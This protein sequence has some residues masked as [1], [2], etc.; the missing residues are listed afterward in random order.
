MASSL[1]HAKRAIQ[2]GVVRA[3][4]H[5]W[6][7]QK[8]RL[9]RWR[10]MEKSVLSIVDGGTHH[11]GQTHAI[12]IIWQPIKTSWSV[13][14]MLGALD[15]AGVNVTLVV[16]HPLPDD[17]I[18]ALGRRVAR[19]MLRDNSGRD[20]GGYRDATL[21]LEREAQPERVLYLNDS[22]Y[23]FE[24]GLDP[25]VKRLVDS[26][27]DV[28]TA[29]ECWKP[30]HHYQ[31]FCYSVSGKLFRSSAWQGFWNDYLPVDSRLWAIRKG[32]IASSAVM[33]RISESI[34]VVFS[35]A[36]LQRS[37][38]GLSRDEL[39]AHI[40][41]LPE[42]LRLTASETSRMDRSAIMREITA[43][44][45][46]LSQIHTG[47]M[48]FRRFIDCPLMKRDIVFR[49]HYSVNEV[50]ILLDEIGHEGHAADILTDLRRRGSG[51]S[52]GSWNR[53]RIRVGIL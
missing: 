20:I 33:N 8:A 49:D 14:N 17:R 26:T 31:S 16:N 50:E 13:W 9:R 11:P 53:A 2:R 52:S 27:A 38:G 46:T 4:D 40:G 7:I 37:L 25:L 30:R 47:G 51:A 29:F 44:L 18:E 45:M 42:P 28:C 19:V 22:V 43:Q 1:S 21:F 5:V 35:L 48:L 41:Y 3:V 15:R 34:E 39:K 10:G 12:F 6:P 24:R 36:A 32:E 23:I